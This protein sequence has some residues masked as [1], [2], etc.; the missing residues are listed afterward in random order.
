MY[1]KTALRSAPFTCC[2]IALSRYNARTLTVYTIPA[3][4]RVYYTRTIPCILYPHY[5]VY[6]IPALYRVYYTRTIPCILYPH[7]TVY[8]IPALY[9]VYYTRTI[10]CILYPHYTVYT[11]PGTIL[12][13]PIVYTSHKNNSRAKCSRA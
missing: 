13:Q 11:I 10:P 7:Y 4:Y 2:A 6:T 9:R 12:Y 5:T 8:T 1:R 3:L